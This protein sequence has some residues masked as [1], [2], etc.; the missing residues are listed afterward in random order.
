MGLLVRRTAGR[1]RW[2]G[3][4]GRAVAVAVGVG[5]GGRRRCRSVARRYGE[6]INY[7]AL[8]LTT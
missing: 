1:G 7:V 3:D 6:Q 5:R 4:V 8:T 2:W